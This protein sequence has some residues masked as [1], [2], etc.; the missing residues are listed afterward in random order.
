MDIVPLN[1][2]RV[3]SYDQAQE[4]LPVIYRITEV[5]QKE[6]RVLMNR[7]EAIKGMSGARATDLENEINSIIDRWQQ[8]VTKLGASPKGLWLADFDNGEGYYCWK[9]P[10]AVISYWHG[11]ND[12]FSGRILIKPELNETETEKSPTL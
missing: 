11:Y 9:F 5:A 1:H 2:K 12:G 4:L 3:F 8:K 10:E 6:V 7:I